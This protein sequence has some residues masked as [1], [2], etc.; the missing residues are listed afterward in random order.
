MNAL[1]KL[2]CRLFGHTGRVFHREVSR[3][4]WVPYCTRCKRPAL[5]LPVLKR[6]R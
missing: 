3:G 2:W 5:E 4:Y 1:R 6:A